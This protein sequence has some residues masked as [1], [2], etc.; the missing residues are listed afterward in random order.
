MTL[1]VPFLCYFQNL[2]LLADK[3]IWPS[4]CCI[5]LLYLWAQKVF[6]IFKILFQNR[7]INTFVLCDVFF[8]RYVQ[9]KSSFSD[10][11][12]SMKSETHLIRE[13]IKN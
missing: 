4:F 5:V 13:A 8:S 9:L 11:K 12:N 10:E 3:K 1:A 6:Q 7:D 2:Q